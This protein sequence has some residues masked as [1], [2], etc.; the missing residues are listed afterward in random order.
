MAA[1]MARNKYV[2]NV[3]FLSIA[4]GSLILGYNFVQSLLKGLTGS[5]FDICL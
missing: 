3:V 2:T 5:V 1:S 4:I